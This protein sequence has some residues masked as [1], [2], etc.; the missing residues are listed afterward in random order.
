MSNTVNTVKTVATSNVSIGRAL[1]IAA[2]V[3]GAVLAQ[4][5]WSTFFAVI[6]PFWAWYLV[7]ERIMQHYGVI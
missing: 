6:L 2:W 5:F 7:A 1:L 4:G 3:S